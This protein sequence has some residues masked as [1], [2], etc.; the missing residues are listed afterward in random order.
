MGPEKAKPYFEKYG[1]GTE[2]QQFPDI[3]DNTDEI[4]A[5]HNKILPASI[6]KYMHAPYYDLCLGSA[7]KR[8]ADVTRLYF[9]YAYD[10]AGKL[11]CK[12]IIVHH[13]YIPN[14]SRPAA[15]V[16]RAVDFWQDFFRSHKSDVKVFMENQF[17]QNSNMLIEIIDKCNDPRLA[18]NLDIGHAHAFSDLPVIEWIEQLNSRIGYVHLHQNKGKYDEHLG[19]TE[20]TMD[21]RAV[22]T[23][24]EKYAPQAVWALE[25]GWEKLD[26]SI[27]FLID[28]GFVKR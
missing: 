14:T 19:L 21:M 11:G 6:E 8:I 27:A 17:E 15:W 24:L 20:G 13:G 22:L 4:I 7:N 10:V 26:D 28:C 12:G 1:F 23:T 5:L 2:I 16:E 18:V 25:F 9:D 3:M